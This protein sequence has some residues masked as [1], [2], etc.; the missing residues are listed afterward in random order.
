[1]SLRPSDFV[2]DSTNFYFETDDDAEAHYLC[3]VLNAPS[4][5]EAVKPFQPVGAYG[6]RDIGRRPLM[7]SIPKF[8]PKNAAHL[9]LAKLSLEA[10]A[11]VASIKFSG[12]GFRTRRNEAIQ[13]LSSLT[14]QIDQI[15]ESLGMP[16]GAEAVLVAA[17][18]GDAKKLSEL[19]E[20]PDE[21]DE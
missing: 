21:D 9:S 18:Q 12:P 4:I 7:L 3:A 15:V 13:T 19:E 14:G 11:I 1:M 6:P 16:E 5:S 20:R 8:D 10:H 2:A 17:V